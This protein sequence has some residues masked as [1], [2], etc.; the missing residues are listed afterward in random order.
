MMKRYLMYSFLCI[1]VISSTMSQEISYDSLLEL[2]LED[3]LNMKV[4]VASKK[5]LTTRESPGILT[6]ISAEEIQAQGSRDLIDVLRMVPGLSFSYDVQ[7][8]VGIASRGSW[9]HEGK[10]LLMLNGLELN[11]N[12]YSTTIFGNHY[13][14]NQIKRIEIIRGPGSS[15]YGGY[16][17]LGVI[18]IITKSGED[19][20]GVQVAGTYGQLSE[21]TGRKN[22]SFQ[23]GKSYDDLQFSIGAFAGAGIRSEEN[24]VDIYSGTGNMAENSDLKPTSVNFALKYK[25]LSLNSFYENYETT[26][27]AVFDEVAPLTTSIAFRTLNTQLAYD[28]KISDKVTL[29]PRVS[30]INQNPWST[31]DNVGLEEDYL[32]NT[33]DAY[34]DVTVNKTVGNLT[35]NIDI[36]DN[37]NLILGTEYFIEKANDNDN[38][39]F[40][41]GKSEID[42]NTLSGFGQLSYTSSIGNIT[43]GGRV[44]NHNQFGS[45]FA[46]RFGY[47]K[48]FN[49]FHGK[50]LLSRAFRAPGIENINLNQDVIPEKTTVAEIEL[51]YKLAS[52]MFI[53]ANVFDIT[54]DDP[55]IYFFDD[56]TSSEAYLNFSQTGS[57]GFE[58]E[59]QI[60]EKWGFFKLNYSRYSS[61]DKN[62]ADLYAVPGENQAVVGIPQSKLNLIS[63]FKVSKDFSI[64]PSLTLLGTRFAY[65]SVDVNDE[66]VI[67]QLDPTPLVNLN[68]RYENLLTSG[69]DVS[70]GVF[71]LLDENYAFAQPYNGYHSP[72]PGTGREFV[73]K[74]IYGLNFN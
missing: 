66:P 74:L 20:E 39:V 49:K 7:G 9:G 52:N 50:L 27:L 45:A 16:A 62:E 1:G 18:N 68:L 58:I 59:Y 37:L 57:R 40:V 5:A 73:F 36:S 35:S 28:W 21:N 69:L 15:V 70:I 46:P 65:T 44:I 17:E 43:L 47:T 53:T 54:I 14:V 32:R 41:N 51:G 8:T 61:K 13:D 33:V 10:I 3:L 48:V 60:K 19:L 2:S 11:E 25:G 22:L 4:T 64:N 29:T 6:I 23:I 71:D 67:E 12:A 42:F 26:T 72:L 63:S 34:Y 55:I 31:K 30:I 56:V 24:F 38:G